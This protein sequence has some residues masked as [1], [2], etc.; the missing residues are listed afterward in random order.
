MADGPTVVNTGGGGGGGTAVAIVL[1]IIAIIGVLFFTGI[2]D[3]GGGVGSKDV[4]V[5]IDAPKIEA[6]KV[7]TPAAPTKTPSDALAAPAPAPARWPGQAVADDGGIQ[8]A[9]RQG[10]G[11]ATPA[12]ARVFLGTAGCFLDRLRFLNRR[13]AAPS[14]I[15]RE[16]A[17]FAKF[18][19]DIQSKID[20][21][22]PASIG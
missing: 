5:K 3:V 15:V 7:E 21:Q 22:S 14:I 20:I 17:L 1:A 19:M 6:P 10:V 12:W 11:V 18:R 13:R 8:P 4:N 2:I 16:I 9:A